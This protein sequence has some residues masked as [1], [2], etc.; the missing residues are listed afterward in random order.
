MLVTKMNDNQNKIRR[1]FDENTGKWYFSI[2]DVIALTTDSTDPRN[3][4][5]V[6]KNRLKNTNYELVTKCNQ[7][8]MPSKDGKSYL[9]DVAD[10]ETIIEI[11]KCIP[12][13]K[14]EIFKALIVVKKVKKPIPFH[15]MRTSRI[16]LK[17]TCGCNLENHHH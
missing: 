7:L 4:W 8:K 17:P 5:K 3:Y 10:A 6:L 2:T 11:I 15:D 12:R 1:H 14:I 9:T 13:A 16:K